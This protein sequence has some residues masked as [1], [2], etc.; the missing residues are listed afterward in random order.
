MRR[1]TFLG[2]AL[3]A[4]ALPAAGCRS[5][6][7]LD[8][9]PDPAAVVVTTER[10]VVVVGDGSAGA[11]RPV[12]LA[13]ADWRWVV[14]AEPDGDTTLVTVRALLTEEVRH[15]AT[16]PGRLL[17]QAITPD[18]RRLALVTAAGPVRPPGLHNPAVVPPARPRTT[19]VVTEDG[20]ERAR[21]DLP[22]NLLPDSF[23]PDGGHLY[24]YDVAPGADPPATRVRSIDL[25]TG[26]LATPAGGE[27][28]AAHWVGAVDDPGRRLRYTLL[29]D[30][31]GG[32]AFVRRMRLWDGSVDV[33]D[34]PAPFGGERPGVHILAASADQRRLCAVYNPAAVAVGLDPD[35]LAPGAVNRFADGL[36]GKPGAAFTASGRLVVT[37]DHIAVATNPTLRIAT[38]GE[39]RGLA[40][41]GDGRAWIGDPDGVSQ[42]DLDSG[43]EL[44]RVAVPGMLALQHALAGRAAPA[45]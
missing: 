7:D 6:G 41:A 42:Y 19:V 16:L 35:R 5:G 45:S 29:V 38:R 8:P 4:G 40:L 30:Q 23:S 2:A 26:H 10:G 28:L 1:R 34:L 33:I 21:L 20:A 14:A 44:S 11:P 31:R 18:G 32:R 25:R 3:A 43:R 9:A 27:P 24:A 39:S 13:T 22:G 12:A 15:R 17:P 37:G 36:P